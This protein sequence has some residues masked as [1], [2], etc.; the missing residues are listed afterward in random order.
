MNS[1]PESP[2]SYSQSSAESVVWTTMSIL[3]W[4][5]QFLKSK[6]FLTPRL[7]AEVLLAKAMDCT[8]VQ[9]YTQFDKPLSEDERGRFRDFLRRRSAGEPVAYITGVR[10]F[11]GRRFN[12][13][14]EVLIPRP[15]TEL[16][17]DV[18]ASNL[19]SSVIEHPKLLDLCT[20]SGCIAVSLALEFPNVVLTALDC[21][22]SALSFAKQNAELMGASER[23]EFM[24]HDLLRQDFC[25]T[26]RFD[27]LVSNP[28]Y[29][30]T[31]EVEKLDEGVRKFEPKIALDG[32]ADG[33]VFYRRI[34]ELVPELLMPGGVVAVEVGYDQGKKIAELFVAAGLRDVNVHQDL[35]GHERVV[36]GQWP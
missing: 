6:G 1:S 27:F 35:A 23:I 12:V 32:G 25:I 7:D 36:S 19:K 8:R 16:L 30:A 11:Y 26:Q 15:D 31:A 5:I 29:I 18:I 9:L 10:E 20:G 13:G 4:S 28:P 2:S 3:K 22:A 17:V 33:L 34:L 21:S 14:P 24:N